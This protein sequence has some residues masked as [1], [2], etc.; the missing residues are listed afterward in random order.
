M[1]SISSDALLTRSWPC[2]LRAVTEAAA[3][4]AAAGGVTGD[5]TLSG[6]ATAAAADNMVGGGTAGGVGVFRVVVDNLVGG[7]CDGG[8]GTK[9]GVT[10]DDGFDDDDDGRLDEG[11]GV[12]DLEAVGGRLGD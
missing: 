3:L 7:G 4:N 5:G 2:K 10:T 1:N 12:R 8:I 11:L 9:L 6:A